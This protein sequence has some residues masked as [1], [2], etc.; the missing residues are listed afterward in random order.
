MDIDD[1]KQLHDTLA[2]LRKLA[3]AA[4]IVKELTPD[5]CEAHGR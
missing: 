4:V 1:A 5:P 2:A 3:H